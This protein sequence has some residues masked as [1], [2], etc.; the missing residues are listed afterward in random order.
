MQVVTMEICNIRMM[1]IAKYGHLHFGVENIPSKILDL[2]GSS[3]VV[4]PEQ[5][6]SMSKQQLR[7]KRWLRKRS[8]SLTQFSGL[9]RFPLQ[10]GVEFL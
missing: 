7:A 5:S 3:Q 10:S 6:H 2:L 9:I 4:L 8:A 1:G